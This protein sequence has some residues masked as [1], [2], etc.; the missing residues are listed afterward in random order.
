V[1]DALEE[2]LIAEFSNAPAQARFLFSCRFTKILRLNLILLRICLGKRSE[3]GMFISIDR[4]HSYTQIALKK[5]AIPQEGIIYIDLISKLTGTPAEES[6]VKF[7]ASGYA[8]KILSDYFSRAYIHEGAMKHFINLEEM[9]F[10]LVDNLSTMLQYATMDKVKKF[11]GDLLELLKKHASMRAML[12]VD[13]KENPE[14][15]ALLRPYCEREIPVMED[16]L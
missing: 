7:L 14:V 11:M 10:I 4:P 16:W 13:P 1:S 9:N 5:H 6:Q 2:R 8:P 15:H 3:K 12:I